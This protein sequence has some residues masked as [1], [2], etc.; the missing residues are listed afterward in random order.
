MTPRGLAELLAI[1][2]PPACVACREP[3]QRADEQLCAGCLRE[4]PWL[5]GRRCPRC[6]LPRHRRGGCPAAGAAF[7]RSWAPMAYEGPARALVAALKFRAAL[8]VVHLMAAQ[9]AATLPSELRRGVVVPVPAQ[10]ARRRAR[11]FDPAGALAGALA[12]R[13]ELPLAPVLTRHDRAA[14]QTRAGR[15]ARRAAGRL[16]VR[17]AAAP[18]ALP[19][20]LVDDVHTTGATL[21]VCAAALA[22]AGARDIAAVTYARTLE[23]S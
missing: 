7:A 19:V 20:L 21:A 18:G 4:L 22:A 17:A 8:P 6:G 11:G 15:S 1:V 10:P 2:A 3:L 5:R 16:D 23:A 13:L 9:V 12:D 14:R